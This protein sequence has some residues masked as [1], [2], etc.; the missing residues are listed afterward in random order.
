MIA[1]YGYRR[2]YGSGYPGVTGRGVAGRG[3][4]FYFWPLAWGGIAD[5][6]TAAYLH[7]DEVSRQ[8]SLSFSPTS[9]SHLS[10]S[11]RFAE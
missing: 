11:V 5:V 6:G 4:P 9:L 7:S 1:E 2:T 8:D 3:F 10:F